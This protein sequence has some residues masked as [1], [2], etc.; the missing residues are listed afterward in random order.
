M[1]VRTNQCSYARTGT[2]GHS[3]ESVFVTPSGRRAKV[4]DEHGALIRSATLRASMFATLLSALPRPALP[5]GAS[6]AE[7][8]VEAV[9]VQEAAGLEPITDGR[10]AWRSLDD[11]LGGP[12][13]RP[14][15]AWRR[16]AALT[17]RAV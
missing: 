4:R 2:N 17:R 1:P 9:R 3:D 15:E 11:A 6:D 13:P 12:G 16:A 14:L 7:A 5:S 8:I 10:L